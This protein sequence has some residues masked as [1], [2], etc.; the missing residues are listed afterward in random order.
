MIKEIC[1]ICHT[2][3]ILEKD[4]YARHDDFRGKKLFLRKYYHA[5]CFNN[6]FIKIQQKVMQTIMANIPAITKEV[7]KQME[8]AQ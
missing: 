5:M 4:D 2:E 1:G 3:I 8:I 7:K 6:L